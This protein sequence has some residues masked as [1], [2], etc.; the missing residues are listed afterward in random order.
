M[1]TLLTGLSIGVF[2]IPGTVLWWVA[3]SRQASR[4]GWTTVGGAAVFG[5]GLTGVVLLA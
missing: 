4:A 5:F 2:L 3:A 1:L